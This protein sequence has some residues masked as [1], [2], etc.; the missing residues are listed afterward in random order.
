MVRTIHHRISSAQET[1]I[2]TFVWVKAHIDI[3]GNE[4]AD[5]AA[6]QAATA[7]KAKAY[8]DFPLSHAKRFIRTELHREWEHEYVSSERAPITRGWF[9]TLEDIQKYKLVSDGLTFETTQFL[10]GHAFNREYLHR[11]KIS[12]TDV[13]PC[14]QNVVQ[15]IDHLLKDC[16]RYHSERSFY[17]GLCSEQRVSPFTLK[18]VTRHRHLTTAFNDFITSIV[19]SLKSF[20]TIT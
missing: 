15:S 12:L 4:L 3:I 8:T 14:D 20:N 16:P 6:K 2:I 10:S 17:H 7:H 19:R 13:C 1:S 9:P 11:F 18:D 5:E